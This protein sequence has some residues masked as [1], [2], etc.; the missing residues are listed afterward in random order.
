MTAQRISKTFTAEGV[1]EIILL[2][3]GY[4]ASYRVTRVSTANPFAGTIGIERVLSGGATEPM[5]NVSG[6]LVS[7]DSGHRRN[8]IRNDLDVTIAVRFVATGDMSAGAV[9]VLTERFPDTNK[10]GAGTPPPL[11]QPVGYNVSVWEAGLNGGDLHKT[12]IYLEDCPLTV[13]DAT[14]GRG[15]KIYDFPEGVIHI[16][17]SVGSIQVTTTSDPDTTLN[18]GAT[19]NWGIG[20]TVQA[21]GTLATT[22]Q[23]IIPT[24]NVLNGAAVDVAGALSGSQSTTPATFDG[25]SFALDA[26]LNVGLADATEIDG[27][28]FVNINGFVTIYWINLGDY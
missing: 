17:G 5:S 19:L 1:S 22:E 10:T 28:A 25:H 7:A 11:T 16:L 9:T 20:S 6:V 15:A 12:T 27:D 24:K 14:V 21:N 26:Y 2:K 3:P 13:L 8:D 4:R 23:D 18:N